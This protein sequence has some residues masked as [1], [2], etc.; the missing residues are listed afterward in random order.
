MSH[1]VALPFVVQRR[2]DVVVRPA[3]DGS[4]RG[5]F[6]STAETVD[7]LLI[8]EGDHVV[9]QWSVARKTDHV[10][11]EI[12]SDSEIEPV[13]EV[14]LPLGGIAT[15]R[16]RWTWRRWRRRW[17]V[18]VT[19]ADLRT[20]EPLADAGGLQ[21]AHAGQLIIDVRSG[22]RDAAAAFVKELDF[23][24]ADE[25]LRRAEAIDAGRPSSLDGSAPARL[26]PPD[27]RAQPGD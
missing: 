23:A 3:A 13:Q 16:L 10:G 14:V 22:D 7:G 15:P 17:Q 26:R 8:L 25:A 24:L 4:T 19:A 5:S 1:T 12:R 11:G 18:V 27:D 21:L 2:K 6:T 20:L 9:V